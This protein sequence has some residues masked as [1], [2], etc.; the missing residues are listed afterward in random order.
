MNLQ[1]EEISQIIKKQ[2]RDYE[3]TVDE[4]EIGRVITVGDGI[5]RVHGL[6]RCMA[7]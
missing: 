6:T 5:A 2:I 1:P 4:A 7:G 3:T